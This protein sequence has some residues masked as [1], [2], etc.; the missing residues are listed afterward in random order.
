M[1]ATEAIV[2][3]KKNEDH[4]DQLAF[5]RYILDPSFGIE[6]CSHPLQSPKTVP[7]LVL[8]GD[9]NN[10]NRRKSRSGGRPQSCA[11]I[12]NGLKAVPY[13]VQQF[14]GKQEPTDKF[15]MKW[16]DEEEMALQA[17]FS[18]KRK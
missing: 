8:R 14:L 13:L 6:E 16:R 11:T 1:Q 12:V 5:A 4:F 18:P 15:L 10:V 9:G 2:I 17:E 3:D 7:G